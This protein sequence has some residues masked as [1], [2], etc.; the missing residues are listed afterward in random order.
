MA[1]E[2]D[3]EFIPDDIWIS[4]FENLSSAA[5]IAVLARTCQRFRVLARKPLLREIRWGKFESTK[6][7]LDAWKS[8]DL[9]TLPRKV[10]I[11][12]SF[13]FCSKG[14]WFYMTEEMRLH[15]RIHAQLQHFS[16]LHEL[17]LD[18]TALS[19]YTYTVLA[20]LPSLR[21]LSI[22]DCTFI[23]LAT[24]FYHHTAHATH[25]PAPTF[26]FTSLPLTSLLLHKL[27]FPTDL[28]IGGFSTE[29]DP[30]HPL[31]LLLAPNIHTLSLAWTSA[32]AIMY[33][34]NLWRLTNIT[35]LEVVMPF[36]TRDLVDA[37]VV[38]T[39]RCAPDV[40]VALIV[41]HHNLSEQQVV[42]GVY[43]PIRGVWKY[44]GPLS[45]ATW[46]PQ[47]QPRP[48]SRAVGED[49][50]AVA[51]LTHL[52]MNVP[53][54]V[55]ALVH[56]LEKLPRT[57]R[58][59]EVQMRK[60]DVEVLYAIRELFPLLS[61]L[62]V[63]YGLGKLPWNFLVTLGSEILP[64]LAH[65]HTLTIIPDPACASTRAVDTN[66]NLSMSAQSAAAG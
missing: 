54:E 21:S 11:G 15:D 2:F 4:I 8:S 66:L 1:K 38:F 9:V 41:D 7:N 64:K 58:V 25:A 46:W 20:S 23:P 60:W 48:Q 63:R 35:Q 16:M 57:M 24:P 32:R 50:L 45:F 19:P 6:R 33:A 43:I 12:I 37:L 36:L 61:T 10:A 30:N 47:P 62:V 52:T 56:G 29:D 53:A 18:G 40:R 13:D 55:S 65:L 42:G 28:G 39:D 51:P 27:A 44:K 14:H 31:H 3:P 34:N 22:T 59:L 49:E 17:I 5:Q 26:N